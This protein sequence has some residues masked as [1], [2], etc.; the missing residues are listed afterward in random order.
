MT[1]SEIF[2]IGNVRSC[3]LIR[4][5]RTTRPARRGAAG[6]HACKECAPLIRGAT[7][8]LIGV[9]RRADLHG[10]LT[11]RALL[12]R[13]YVSVTLCAPR[14]A[15]SGIVRGLP[16]HDIDI[17]GYGLQHVHLVVAISSL[18]WQMWNNYN[19]LRCLCVTIITTTR[20]WTVTWHEICNRTGFYRTFIQQNAIYTIGTK[21]LRV[22]YTGLILKWEFLNR[23]R[24]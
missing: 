3:Y 11:A 7:M 4:V 18:S 5:T 8:G 13:S 22:S 12:A 6:P 16:Y 9:P 15:A 19:C 20:V 2:Q 17:Y 23:L 24:K 10:F 21:H 14:R 1:T